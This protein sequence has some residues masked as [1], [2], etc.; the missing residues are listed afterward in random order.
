MKNSELFSQWR[1]FLPLRK[2]KVE[3]GIPPDPDVSSIFVLPCFKSI[4]IISFHLH[5][6]FHNGSLPWSSPVIHPRRKSSRH[7]TVWGWTNPFDVKK[8]LL[9]L[10]KL[11][12]WVIQAIEKSL[13]WVYLNTVRIK[14]V[15]FKN[16]WHWSYQPDM[17]DK[18][19]GLFRTEKYNLSWW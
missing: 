18:R 9:T 3:H 14:I 4:L 6:Q 5:L 13:S 1:N 7:L 12:P 16:I 19:Q 8:N 10:Q 2:L 15:I 17:T 11:E